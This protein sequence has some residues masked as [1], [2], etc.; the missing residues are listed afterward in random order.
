MCVFDSLQKAVQTCNMQ[1]T[2]ILKPVCTHSRSIF[3][4]ISVHIVPFWLTKEAQEGC[5]GPSLWPTTKNMSPW[6]MVGWGLWGELCG[7]DLAAP[8]CSLALNLASHS[9]SMLLPGFTSTN[10]KHTVD[11]PP[12][13][14]HD[15]III[16]NMH[17]HCCTCR[18]VRKEN[19]GC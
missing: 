2:P 17:L 13:T 12:P 19:F 16:I 7:K 11:P 3:A 8:C 9:L 10:R 14:S 6:S 18:R 4:H 15:V 1:Y 5:V